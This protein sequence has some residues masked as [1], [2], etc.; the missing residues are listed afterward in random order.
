MQE[1]AP[2]YVIGYPKSGNTWLLRMLCEI[3]DANINQTDEINRATYKESRKNI[4]H[5]S[6]FEDISKLHSN[7]KFIYIVRDIRDV[8]VSGFFYT[9][10]FINENSVIN[11]NNIDIGSL[12]FR[13]YFKY[14]I[15]QLNLRWQYNKVT[16][17][18]HWILSLLV[19]L[20]DLITRRQPL[21]KKINLNWSEH[22]SY[23]A[24]R[25]N[26]HLVRYEDL[27]SNT[28]LEMEKILNFLHLSYSPEDLN[29]IVHEQ[30]FQIK[31]QQFKNKGDIRNTQFMRQGRSGD[32]IRFLDNELVNEI[33]QS[34]EKCLLMMGY[35]SYPPMCQ[36]TL[37]PPQ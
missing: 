1:E 33:T 27:L 24:N 31:K 18:K 28:T 37:R 13:C 17:F 19:K 7:G 23:W 32:W 8:L 25:P 4:I 9:H 12:L 30:S 36:A 16:T 10:H 6:H 3:C 34:H 26:I 14:Q 2:I 15:K 20:K 29:N 5:K 22:I 11:K 21:P 35:L